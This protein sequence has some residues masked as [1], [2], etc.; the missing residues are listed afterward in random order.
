M[1]PGSGDLRTRPY[2]LAGGRPT[3]AATAYAMFNLQE[4]GSLF[5]EPTTEV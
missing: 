3:G 1:S 5:S 4:R 2:R